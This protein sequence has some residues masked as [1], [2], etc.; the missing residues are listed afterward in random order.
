MN[1]INKNLSD[2][3][4]YRNF[5]PKNVLELILLFIIFMFWA[6]PFLYISFNTLLNTL[7]GTL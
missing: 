5:F 6:K 2:N 1:T 3:F 7:L 4:K